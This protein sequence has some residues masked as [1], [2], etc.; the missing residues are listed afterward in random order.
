MY[1]DESFFRSE[2]TVTHTWGD[3]EARKTVKVSS[4]AGTVAVLG[5]VDPKR[6]DHEEMIVDG[7][8]DSIVTNI[9]LQQLSKAYP[10]QQIL[11]IWDNASFHKTQGSEKYPLPDNIA[12]LYL[13]PYSPDLNY[14]EEVWK[15]VKETDHKNVLYTSKGELLRIVTETFRKYK[16]RK[17][18]F[19]STN[20][21][22]TKH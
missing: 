19:K 21:K 8:V 18:K 20:S 22:L 4:H 7:S 12:L 2:T 13:P 3:R 17:F 11:L 9:F 1:A 10:N 5:A 6:G 15:I 14:S 16:K